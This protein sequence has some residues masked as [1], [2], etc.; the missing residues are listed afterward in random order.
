M[1]QQTQLRD[2]KV[3]FGHPKIMTIA[4]ENYPQTLV[5]AAHD[6]MHGNARAFSTETSR[7]EGEG[8]KC[9]KS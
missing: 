4:A 2:E 3:C 5:D 7:R 6:R 9:K 1:T 8:V